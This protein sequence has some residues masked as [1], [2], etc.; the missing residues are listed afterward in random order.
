MWAVVVLH[1]QNYAQVTLGLNLENL[2]R[3]GRVCAYVGT[4]PTHI[5]SVN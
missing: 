3:G 4:V 5:S 1:Q 2:E